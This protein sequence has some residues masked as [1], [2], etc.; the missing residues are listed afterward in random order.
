MTTGGSAGEGRL[1]FPLPAA[2]RLALLFLLVL[3]C[4]APSL[5]SGFVYDDLQLIVRSRPPGSLAEALGV[6]AE[7][8][9]PTLPY[10]RPVS[11]VTM[12]VQQAL[13]GADP[14]PYHLFNAL[15]MAVTSLLAYALLRTPAF[16]IPARVAWL[17]AALFALHPIASSTVHPICSGRETLLPA[18]F[19]IACVACFL[20]PGRGFGALAW[21]AFAAALLS[22][23]QAI[24]LPGILLL[25]DLLGLSAA[26]P[27]RSPTAWLRRHAPFFALVGAYLLVRSL[28]LDAGS[29]ARVVAWSNPAGPLRSL[30]FTLQT[31]L[32]PFVEVVYE[33]RE[34]VWNVGWRRV[35]WPL[36]AVLAGVAV[37]LRWR[38]VGRRVLFFAGWSVLSVALTS[39]L[40][41]Q[42]A[43]FAERYGF[44]ALLG[45]VGIA[46]VLGS[47]VWE[48]PRW[49]RGVT[50]AGVAALAACGWI[51]ASRA[52]S[53]RDDR[54]FLEQWLRSDPGSGQAH[55]SLANHHDRE[56]D[57]AAAL[58]HYRRALEIGPRQ[59]NVLH[60]LGALLLR[61]GD[62]DGAAVQL[63]RAVRLYP[64]F[65]RVRFDLGRTYLAR[66]ELEAA[67]AQLEEAVRL[68]PRVH[69]GHHQ[70][71][72]VLLRLDRPEPARASLERA[73]ALAPRNPAVHRDMAA[74]LEALGRA[75]E[76]GAHR[77]LGG[78]GAEANP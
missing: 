60:G 33:P 54:V 17:G 27:G 64:R 28:V 32:T 41:H 21:L 44:L 63:E 77:R 31:T 50:V 20:R 10:Y 73:L 30:Y 7:P 22:K 38:S 14:A 57:A 58:L 49:R 75:D 52:Q 76:A 1:G 47:S 4:Y 3:A 23:E 68:E 24:V 78:P 35:A 8:H 53:Y 29:P 61:E 74:A 13:H 67:L 18:L 15:A 51:S 46:A 62:L 59:R 9:W 19:S 39:N 66:G 16:G 6:F 2:L 72:V 5:K 36:L 12:V 25:A 70:L 55:L 26:P 65:A 11:R 69:R 71:G 48:R 34:A 45:F 40:L 43:P 42:Q 37:A 56:G